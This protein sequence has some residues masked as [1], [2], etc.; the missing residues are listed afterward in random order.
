MK[1]LNFRVISS[2][3]G[4]LVLAM[5]AIIP[6]SAN[7]PTIERGILDFDFIFDSCGF[8]INAHL[9]GKGVTFYFWDKDDV[10]QGVSGSIGGSNATITYNGHTLTWHNVENYRWT[11]IGEGLSLMQN[12][13]LVWGVSVPGYGRAVARSGRSVDL[14]HQEGTDLIC[15]ENLFWSGMYVEEIDAVCNYLVNGK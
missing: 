6:V 14:C 9:Y 4:V 8:D 13:G 10:I 12:T 3:L 5:V 7:M 2:I 15:D 11:V 1:R